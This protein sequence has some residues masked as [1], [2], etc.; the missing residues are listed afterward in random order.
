[1]SI[2]FCTIDLY[3]TKRTANWISETRVSAFEAGQ[4]LQ[5]NRSNA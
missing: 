3:Q 1:M 5:S 4:D 2:S